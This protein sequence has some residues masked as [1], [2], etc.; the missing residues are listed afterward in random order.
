MKKLLL[1]LF[2]FPLVGFAQSEAFKGANTLV[3]SSADT[4][5]Q[6]MRALIKDGFEIK[7]SNA[8]YQTISTGWKHYQSTVYYRLA[9]SL[10]QDQITFRGFFKND[11]VNAVFN[12]QGAETPI[13]WA[14]SGG[15]SYAWGL[16]DSFASYFGT[17]KEYFKK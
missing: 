15:M 7:D 11:G 16:M 6:V 4:Y 12:A 3:V 1:I 14:K 17:E 2:F 10:D 8:E 13:T 5:D 9:I